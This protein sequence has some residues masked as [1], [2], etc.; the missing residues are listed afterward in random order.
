[1]MYVPQDAA[2]ALAETVD[3][4][5]TYVVGEFGIERDG[6]EEALAGILEPPLRLSFGGLCVQ[7]DHIQR[8]GCDAAHRKQL[9]GR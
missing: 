4:E 9:L 7:S 8:A 6:L 2:T 1:M 5:A 3:R